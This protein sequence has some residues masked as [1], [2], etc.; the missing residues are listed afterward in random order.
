MAA[1]LTI[2]QIYNQ[3][4]TE[5]NS[6]S[7]LNNLNNPSQTAIWN[8]WAYLTAVA[9]WVQTSLWALFESDTDA[10]IALAPSWTAQWVQAQ[11]FKFQYS[12]SIPQV[13]TLDSN[14]VPFYSTVDTTLQIIS[15]CSV[16]TQP[17]RIVS[18]KVA[19]SNPPQALTT[20]QTLSLTGY[21]DQISPAGVQYNVLSASP[22]QMLIGATV[23]YDGQYASTIQAAV[24]ASINN[25]MANIEFDGFV[26]ISALENAILAT[27]GV[28]DCELNNVAIRPSTIAFSQ[29]TYLV[30]NN[31]EIFNKYPMFA[32]YVIP[33]TTAGE[34]LTDTLTFTIGS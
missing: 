23:Y 11:C 12:S 4:L 29:T 10:A 13:V 6:L 27:P 2:N 34:T 22:D 15:R 17:N 24:I 19:T 33:E 18:V 9:I 5:K 30:Q 31:T 26:R 20:G 3:I 1:N 14:F 7:S 28:N 21:L 8:M 25:Y 32:G 16:V